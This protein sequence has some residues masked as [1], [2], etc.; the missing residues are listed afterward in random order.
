MW[1]VLVVFVFIVSIFISALYID[2]KLEETEAAQRLTDEKRRAYNKDPG[3][4]EY[5][6]E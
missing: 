3:G 2:K 6:N 1:V 4:R 5:D